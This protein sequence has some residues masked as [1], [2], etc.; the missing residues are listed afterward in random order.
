MLARVEDR[1][2]K[3]QPRN[4][5]HGAQGDPEFERERSWLL[6]TVQVVKNE[7]RPADDKKNYESI[8]ECSCC[9][10]S[11][12]LVSFFF[13]LLESV[14]FTPFFFSVLLSDAQT[15]TY[16][17]ENA[18]QSTRKTRSFVVMKISF[19]WSRVDASYVSPIQLYSHALTAGCPRCICD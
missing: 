11:M 2:K 7:E 6:E 10:N 18:F 13:F 5:S 9:S 3:N 15:D 4:V 14:F 17:V 19:A 16:F 8:V 12:K 1:L